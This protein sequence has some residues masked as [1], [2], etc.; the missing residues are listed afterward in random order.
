MTKNCPVVSQ[1]I[2]PSSTGIPLSS[3]FANSNFVS[4]FDIFMSAV[5]LAFARVQQLYGRERQ[6]AG[7]SRPHLLALWQKCVLPLFTSHQQSINATSSAYANYLGN[8]LY[9]PP[10]SAAKNLGRLSCSKRI[11]SAG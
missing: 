11:Q 2:F 6:R 8:R 3:S 9:R 5:A 4:T 1:I 10:Q 7:E